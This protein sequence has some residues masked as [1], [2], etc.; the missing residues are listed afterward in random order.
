[1]ETAQAQQT[2]ISFWAHACRPPL[3]P[4]WFLLFWYIYVM[5]FFGADDASVWGTA[6]GIMF[7][8]G[9]TL[10]GNMYHAPFEKYWSE[11]KWA[12]LRVFII[13]FCVSSY[14]SSVSLQQDKFVFIFPK[15]AGITVGGLVLAGVLTGSLFAFRVLAIKYGYH[16]SK[17]SGGLKHQ[18]LDE[19]VA[20]HVKG[21]DASVAQNEDGR[22]EEVPGMTAQHV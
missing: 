20:T 4:V 14:S 1:M 9:F 8:I 12:T 15:D 5:A 18:E 7:I 22:Q 11:K 21:G 6:V 17:T 10:T 13:P 19:K 3:M 2:W 16:T